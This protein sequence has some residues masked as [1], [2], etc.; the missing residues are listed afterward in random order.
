[1]LYKIAAQLGKVAK[2]WENQKWKNEIQGPRQP[3]PGH[4]LYH[5]Q[6]SPYAQRVR[7]CIF[8]LKLD[9]PFKDILLDELAYQELVKQGGIDQVPC[10]RIASPDGGVKWMYES[11]D[12]IAY[13]KK[14]AVNPT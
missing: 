6:L 11:K 14:V 10:M 2:L 5:I 4:T 9:L 12:I 1:M 13:L 7:A 8:R 3:L